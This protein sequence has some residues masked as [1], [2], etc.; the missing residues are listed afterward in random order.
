ML[1]FRIKKI[2]KKD[3]KCIFRHNLTALIVVTELLFM[4]SCSSEELT[5][6]QTRLPIRL[7]A[8]ALQANTRTENTNIQNS[9][10][11]SS[12]LISAYIKVSGDGGAW[13][14]NPTV[15]EAQ[16]ADENHVNP[17]VP[18][19]Q[20]FFPDGNITIDIHALYPQDT[21][22]KVA[23]QD[24]KFIVPDEQKT[25]QD[26]RDGDLMFASIN[27]QLKT[28]ATITLPFRHKMAKL[29]ITAIGEDGVEIKNV[30]LIN[31]DR[32]VVFDTT[33]GT[34]GAS[35]NN[36]SIDLGLGGAALIPPQ[37][38]SSEFIQVE[39]G[40]DGSIATFAVPGKEFES[41]KEY[42]A[43]LVIGQ[44]NLNTIA[45]ITDW[46]AAMG[47]TA[48]VPNANTA[49]DVASIEA[50]EYDGK[51]K[52]PEP[53]YVKYDNGGTIVNLTD[54][55]EENYDLMYYNN[56]NAGTATMIVIGK[57]D[58]VKNLAA[59]K[60][61]IIK[62]AT[63][64]LSYPDNNADQTVEFIYN[65]LVNNPLEKVGDGT[66]TFTSGD[67][68]VAYI[69]TISGQVYV[70]GI[71]T[72]TIRA[73]MAGDK[74][75]TADEASYKLIVTQRS[76]K[77]SGIEVSLVD[78]PEEG[79][80]TYDGQV[81]EP[82]VQVKDG[83]KLLE[84]DKD[85]TLSFK[86]TTNAGTAT[87]TITGVGDYKES[88]EEKYEIKKATPVITLKN[89]NLQLA[90]NASENCSA[91]T[92]IGTL[93]YNSNHPEWVSVSNAGVVTGLVGAK[94]AEITVSIAPDDNLNPA[95]SKKFK[96][97]VVSSDQTFDY[98]GYVQTFKCPMTG[99]YKLEAWG[100]QGGS[101]TIGRVWGGVTYNYTYDGGAGAYVAGTAKLKEGDVLYVYVGGVG[102]SSGHGGWNGGG[103]KTGSGS[104]RYSGGGGATDISL[105][106]S[107]AGSTTWDEAKH[108]YTRIIVAA[109]GGGT[110]ANMS[111]WG[112][113]A[114]GGY[115]GAWDGQNGT[116][117]NDVGRGGTR[118][119]GGKGGKN[120][121]KGSF[122]KGGNFTGTGS[123]GA[124]GGGWY[125]GGSGGDN[126]RHGA[127]GGGSS[128]MWN[129]ANAS[130]Y[131]SYDGVTKPSTDYYVTEVSKTR[132][133]NSGN[134]KA[135]ISF[136]S[137]E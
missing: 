63:G 54:N 55:K 100:A 92:T 77:S 98:K 87:V 83:T 119:D 69:D 135:K 84:K 7:S 1:W 116:G 56:Q 109:G 106:G 41:G 23:S 114:T 48:I 57:S 64:K 74:N 58:M 61:F 16:E 50:V 111:G 20:P 117:S 6:S 76:L 127:G 103:S 60:T 46:S 110:L 67:E 124:G 37:T 128:Y 82:T 132:G 51:L 52:T 72:T 3:M 121:E 65:S 108:L 126:S 62:Q 40:D 85:Y 105:D 79:Y 71:G 102:D 13:I 59:I 34:L 131:P 8:T 36:G 15:Y 22:E 107:P 5:P 39:A 123:A 26:Y 29:V 134:G 32:S 97:T 43:R 88:R 9:C 11:E 136:V 90:V 27:G 4:A 99:I 2:M 137:T 78:L 81:K 21:K 113:F 89:G 24:G 31:V 120:G 33:T 68:N 28:D 115:G 118:S 49:L 47:I 70:R 17:L 133:T 86:N 125:G 122:G 104:D 30:K 94:E 73:S 66:M 93:I 25:D 19:V 95:E 80:Y 130:Y 14:G 42:E 101:Q 91:E 129:D 10:F 45:T 96:V 112:T 53:E 44:H 18:K 12:E 38:V 35:D 75:Y